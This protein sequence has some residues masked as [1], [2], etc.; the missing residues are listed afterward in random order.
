[1]SQLDRFDQIT[2]FNP[3]YDEEATRR[4]LEAYYQVPH[5]FDDNLKAQVFDHATFY[6]IPLEQQKVQET[7][8]DKE[9]SLMEG[10]KQMGQG[11]LSGFSTFNVGEPSNNEYERIMRSIGELAGF[12]GYVPLLHLRL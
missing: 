2:E 8:A 9:F 4:L 7:L 1:M 12:V 11:F 5:T 10:V 3:F 6:N